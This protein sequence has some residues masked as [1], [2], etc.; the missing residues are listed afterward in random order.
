MIPHT[1]AAP[2]PLNC[3]AFVLQIAGFSGPMETSAAELEIPA[4]KEASM[5]VPSWRYEL[6]KTKLCSAG[7]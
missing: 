6:P 2:K 7:G 3:A 1:I 4:S 5:Q